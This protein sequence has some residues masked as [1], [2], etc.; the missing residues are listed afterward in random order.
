MAFRHPAMLWWLFALIIPV[1]IHL[2]NFRRHKTILFSNI[3]L[4]R[5]LQQE[6]NKTNKL[7]HRLILMMRMLAL[8]ALVIAFARPYAK[9]ERL[10][11]L[12]KNTVVS[13]YVDNSPSMQRRGSTMTFLEEM[14]QQ[15]VRIA[16]SF[17]LNTRYVLLSNEFKPA[18]NRLLGR[19]DFI[20]ELTELIPV[21][22]SADLGDVIRRNHSIAKDDESSN[23]FL[24]LLS[25]FQKSATDPARIP[26]DTNLQLVLLKAG[27]SKD[28]NLYLDTLW[29]E[30]PVLRPGLEARLHL[31]VVNDGDQAVNGVPVKLE[32]NGQ[33]VAITTATVNPN[34][35]TELLLQFLVPQTKGFQ[36]A[37]AS[38]QDY[39]IVFDDEL[40]F[41]FE[42]MS[43][44]RVLELYR[45]KPNPNIALLFQDDDD[46]E[47]QHSAVTNVDI[48]SIAGFQL[49]I[50]NQ[51][52]PLSS[53]L[54]AALD[55]FVAAGGSLVLLP[56]ER[57][58]D[59]FNSLTQR[60]GFAYQLA[61]TT[62]T[63][64]TK[65]E[66]KHP[67]F[68]DV[69]VKIPDQPDLPVVT[70]HF[71][72]RTDGKTNSFRLM[73]LLNDD[74]FLLISNARGS[75]S[76]YAFASPNDPSWSSF[77][78]HALFAPVFYKILYRSPLMH[79]V[80]YVNR[81][82]LEFPIPTNVET[83]AQKLTVQDEGHS[84]SIIPG[85]GHG[86]NSNKLMVSGLLA[87]ASHYDVMLNDSLV[88]MFSVNTDRRESALKVMDAAQLREV[89]NED[90]FADVTLLDAS[91]SWLAEDATALTEIRSLIS[92]FLVLTLVFLLAEVLL[93]RFWK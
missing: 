8:A 39:P 38:V 61:D 74:P 88:G 82:T 72:I 47:L 36:R 20:R 84:I 16:E 87:E 7:K 92:L 81:E 68:S 85:I 58:I 93:V 77:V 91:K 57:C 26:A 37:V 62:A 33:Q 29:F 89:F 30:N 2:F 4:L 3:Q 6:T 46:V 71:P 56:S 40:F 55:S 45:D 76:V 86:L 73:R 66:E 48:Q 43:K 15:A 28:Q 90:N 10:M 1:L 31:V 64:V 60:F 11:N 44:I 80:Y 9:N 24:F 22:A 32:L 65:V 69:F 50:L 49:L 14:R 78:G 34:E 25:D 67:F 12:K 18:R 79:P 53:G 75:G 70:K 54:L 52:Y 17:D 21:A 42:V 51:T 59:D 41:S 5:N 19:D 27:G 23:R 83:D 63:R 13:V 35:R